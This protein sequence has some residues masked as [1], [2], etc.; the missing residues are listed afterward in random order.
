MENIPPSDLL[1]VFVVLIGIFCVVGAF[2]GRMRPPR[3]P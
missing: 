1:K 2:I 3:W